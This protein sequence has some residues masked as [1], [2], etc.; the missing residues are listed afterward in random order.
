[1]APSCHGAGCVDCH[2][3]NGGVH[4]GVVYWS[5]D[6][7]ALDCCSKG[8]AA[9]EGDVTADGITCRRTE[10]FCELENGGTTLAQTK[11]LVILVPRAGGWWGCFQLHSSS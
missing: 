4:G 2:Y 8:S 1:M 5:G 10:L 9:P 3:G 11:L 6:W 7:S